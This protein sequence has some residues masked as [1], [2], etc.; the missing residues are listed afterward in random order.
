[1]NESTSE[2]R[3]SEE[4]RVICPVLRS[5]VKEQLLQPDT[6]GVTRF[7][8]L[9]TVMALFSRPRMEAYA[10]IFANRRWDILGNLLRH[11]FNVFTMKDGMIHHTC[12]SGIISSGRFDEEKFEELA[13]YA[14]SQGRLRKADFLRAIADRRAQQNG[15]ATGALFS[16]I[17]FSILLSSF[18]TN[19]ENNEPYVT[20]DELY[21]LYRNQTLPGQF[22]VRGKLVHEEAALHSASTG[23]AGLTVELWHRRSFSFRHYLELVSILRR[24]VRTLDRKVATCT[25]T[26]KTGDFTFNL[27]GV[28]RLNLQLRV[29]DKRHT[30][31]TQQRKVV[32]VIDAQDAI[33][34]DINL[35]PLRIPFW[36]YDRTYPFPAVLASTYDGKLPQRFARGVLSAIFR[37]RFRLDFRLFVRKW[38]IGRGSLSLRQVQDSFHGLDPTMLQH[39]K[40]DTDRFFVYR[41]MNGFNPAELT[42]FPGDSVI[43][44]V[45]DEQWVQKDPAHKL[46]NSSHRYVVTYDFSDYESDGIHDIFTAILCLTLDQ[47]EMLH[48]TR[49]V[50]KLRKKGE[51]KGNAGYDKRYSIT[52]ETENKGMWKAAK[53]AFRSAWAAAG[54]IDAH[55]GKGHLNAGQYAIAAYRN[56]NQ[57][58]VAKLLLPFLRGVTEINDLGKTSIFG[59]NG[60]LSTNTALTTSAAW[61]RLS[62]VLGTQD[63]ANWQPRTPMYKCH[64]YA[65]AANL[66]WKIVT[67]SVDAFFAEHK[68]G[69]TE[70]WYEVNRFSADLTSNS[71]AHNPSVPGADVP[72]PAT[73]DTDNE[74]ALSPLIKTLGKRSLLTQSDLLYHSLGDHPSDETTEEPTARPRSVSAITDSETFTDD[75]HLESLKQVCRYAIFHATFWH[76]WSNDLQIVDAS[77][78]YYTPL[79]LR[80]GVMPSKVDCSDYERVLPTA[81]EAPAQL[82]FA[83]LL[84]GVRF[85]FI[86]RNQLNEIDEGFINRLKA[87]QKD[88]DDLRNPFQLDATFDINNIRSRTNI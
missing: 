67:D 21:A 41:I 8:N 31:T 1:M 14:D 65:I 19:D 13:A 52:P 61:L 7:S 24:L 48:P 76:G 56:L 75:D 74:S 53:T 33:S 66:Y 5:A 9:K 17:E 63:W 3:D 30:I 49:I 73:Q 15:T 85:G 50:L 79:A 88:F 35:G 69:I 60:V 51:T 80:N 40:E 28:R 25:F 62:D 71:V 81:T 32:C 64:S 38:F 57:N 58:P 78:I 84:T 12:H 20:R 42:P 36:E 68:D 77:N 10:A 39:Q 29:I 4:I 55:L 83:N 11:R 2:D 22:C 46:E 86:T 16:K 59:V 87:K 82:I 44:D 27:T 47:D 23:I 43:H 18:G 72:E 70:Y 6:D 45:P 34:E 54:E 37:C 26:D